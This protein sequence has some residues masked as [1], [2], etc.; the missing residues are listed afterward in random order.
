MFP[1]L[2]YIIFPLIPCGKSRRTILLLY[3]FPTKPK[4]WLQSRINVMS[5]GES[6]SGITPKFSWEGVRFIN[7]LPKLSFEMLWDPK[8]VMNM[9]HVPFSIKGQIPHGWSNP[10][11]FRF[12][13]LG[14]LAKPFTKSNRVIV[15]LL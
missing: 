13:A 3:L 7:E 15:L 10:P 6:S 5:K 4:V 2:L 11:I 14:L 1:I 9:Y 12:V 8:L